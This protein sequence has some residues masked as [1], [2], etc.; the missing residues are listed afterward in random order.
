MLFRST[1]S[2]HDRSHA[3][4]INSNFLCAGFKEGGTDACEYD[5]GGPLVCP[6]KGG[7][8][9]LAGIVSWAQKC[10]QPFKY[11]VYTNVRK[12]LSWIRH[13]LKTNS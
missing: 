7:R 11:G 10:G 8:W 13:R 3:G 1:Y 9:L 4:K 5:E 12:Y 2:F 6:A